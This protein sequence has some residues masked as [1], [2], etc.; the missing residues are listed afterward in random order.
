MPDGGGGEGY[1]VVIVD[2]V[3]G[4]I[5]GAAELGEEFGDVPDGLGLFSMWASCRWV[6]RMFM[7]SCSAGILSQLN[8]L[9]IF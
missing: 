6:M 7:S 4:I 3:G 9:G 5:V 2:V 1:L 8:K